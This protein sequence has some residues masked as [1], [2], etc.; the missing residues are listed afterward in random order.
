MDAHDPMDWLL[1]QLTILKVVQGTRMGVSLRKDF[2]VK[3]SRVKRIKQ[4]SSLQGFSVFNVLTHLS[5]FLERLYR[6]LKLI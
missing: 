5:I 2:V 6:L 1:V 4:I 3:A